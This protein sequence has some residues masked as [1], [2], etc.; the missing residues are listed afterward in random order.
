MITQNTPADEFAHHYQFPG[1]FCA[2][3]AHEFTMKLH[4]KIGLDEFPLQWVAANAHG[5]CTFGGFLQQH[6]YTQTA[7]EPATSDDALKFITSEVESGRCPLLA[8]LGWHI[9][10][11]VKDGDEIRVADPAK[12]GFIT[13]TTAQTKAAIQHVIDKGGRPFLHMPTYA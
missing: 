9:V 2:A 4:G 11:A 3:S 5:G 6:G 10:A 7:H 8:F 1:D 12:R 13:D